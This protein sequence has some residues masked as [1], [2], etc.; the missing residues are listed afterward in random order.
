MG[1]TMR[2]AVA[3]RP[4]TSRSQRTRGI[5]SAQ[6]AHA[7]VRLQPKSAL[8]PDRSLL[9]EMSMFKKLVPV[10]SLL[11]LAGPVFAQGTPSSDSSAS[12]SS[13]SSAKKGSG[14]THTH[15]HAH[16]HS[17]S[18]SDSSAPKS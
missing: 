11:L 2:G 16:S 6:L 3:A 9:V 7:S 12:A 8:S 18:S 4:K 13:S 10:V 17:S 14:K 15:T 5:S 1:G